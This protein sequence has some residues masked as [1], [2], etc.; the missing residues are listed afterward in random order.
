MIEILKKR[1]KSTRFKK[2][3]TGA[4]FL[5]FFSIAFGGEALG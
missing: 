5:G 2:F 3:K 1:G 4:S